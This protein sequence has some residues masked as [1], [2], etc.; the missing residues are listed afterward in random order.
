L[1]YYL[2]TLGLGIYF[3]F[4]HNW[5][6]AVL[7]LII[8]LGDL[9][10]W[11]ERRGQRFSQFLYLLLICV[12]VTATVWAFVTPGWRYFFIGVLGFFHTLS[13][14]LSYRIENYERREGKK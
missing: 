11:M 1:I 5:A 9:F 10:V 6:L 4:L 12:M 8:S 14:G 3:L 13:L 7:W 2:L